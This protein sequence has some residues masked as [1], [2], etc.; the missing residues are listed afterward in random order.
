[1]NENNY[2]KCKELS[3]L[4][5]RA[6]NQDIIT[7]AQR[8]QLSN[9]RASLW[10]AQDDGFIGGESGISPLHFK[11]SAIFLQSILTYLNSHK[12]F[13]PCQQRRKP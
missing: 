12:E 3:R 6:P 13:I 9:I 2:Q 5:K 1:M 10:N 8:H 11:K 7:T 4:I